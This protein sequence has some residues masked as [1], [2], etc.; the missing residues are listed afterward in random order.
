[1]VYTRRNIL[2]SLSLQTA[3]N[4]TFYKQPYT[5]LDLYS[6]FVCKYIIE[7]RTLGRIERIMDFSCA[8]HTFVFVFEFSVCIRI[9]M[10]KKFGMRP[11]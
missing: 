4:R 1:M 10:N 2:Y 8:S 9:F 5:L 3:E 11:K 6:I 7:V